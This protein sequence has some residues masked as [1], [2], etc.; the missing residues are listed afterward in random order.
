VTVSWSVNI[1]SAIVR[2]GTWR[3][4]IWRT[5]ARPSMPTRFTSTSA[6]F[7]TCS[8]TAATS[9]SPDGTI[10]MTSMSGSNDSIV[11]MP[12]ATTPWSSAMT[13]SMT[14]V[15]AWELL[16]VWGAFRAVPPPRPLY[17]RACCC[18]R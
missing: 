11:A 15:V 5:A 3:S 14:S 10:A 9:S 2:V 13:T 18:G 1:V 12:S 8:L 16:T 17:P 6:T 7:G 4:S